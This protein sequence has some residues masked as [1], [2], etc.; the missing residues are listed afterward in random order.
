MLTVLKQDG[1]ILQGTTKHKRVRWLCKCSCGKE[2]FSTTQQ[3]KSGHKKSCGCKKEVQ[4]HKLGTSNSKGSEH[5]CITHLLVTCRRRAAKKGLLFTITREQMIILANAP[6]EYC[7]DTY[8]NLL[9]RTN[10]QYQYNGIDRRDSTLG[11]TLDNV[12][13]CCCTCN[14]MKLSLSVESF[15]THIR[16]IAQ[17]NL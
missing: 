1:F 7:G 5:T 2:T 11:Y 14:Y 13:S 3:L 16:K 15:L 6:C 10:Y 9:T 17:K 4:I 12:V 8:S